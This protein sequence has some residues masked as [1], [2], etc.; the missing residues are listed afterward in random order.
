MSR[1]KQ[2]IRGWKSIWCKLGI[3]KYS[4]LRESIL[5]NFNNNEKVLL[6]SCL[7]KN[8]CKIKINK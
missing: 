5:Y 8:C 2:K 6:Q 4:D 3:H 7:R 1:L